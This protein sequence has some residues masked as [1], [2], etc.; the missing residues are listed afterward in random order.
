MLLFFQYLCL[1]VRARHVLRELQGLPGPELELGVH[2]LSC[3]YLRE[4]SHQMGNQ[5]TC[6]LRYMAFLLLFQPYG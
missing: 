2:S 5:Q 1:Q 4:A 3:L 6:A